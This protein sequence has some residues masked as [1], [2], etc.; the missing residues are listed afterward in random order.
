MQVLLDM[1]PFEPGPSYCPSYFHDA[2]EQHETHRVCQNSI[3]QSD[4]CP[5]PC[6]PEG[7]EASLTT[8]GRVL[9]LPR[10]NTHVGEHQTHL[11]SPHLPYP[12]S[13][14][15]TPPPVIISGVNRCSVADLQ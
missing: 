13:A 14:H 3:S 6:G 5:S 12:F 8:R 2:G 10:P 4:L 1:H 7:K 15:P 11:A 9:V